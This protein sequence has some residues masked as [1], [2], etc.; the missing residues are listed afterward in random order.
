[1][2][3][4]IRFSPEAVHMK[5]NICFPRYARIFRSTELFVKTLAKIVNM[6]VAMTEATMVNKAIRNVKMVIGRARK[7]I[8][9]GRRCG[10]MPWLI[11]SSGEIVCGGRADVAK[12]VVKMATKVNTVA[13]IKRPNIQ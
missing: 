3:K 4:P 6:T 11:F 9:V 10:W 2:M 8:K 5:A 12:G 13:V 1:M 7:K